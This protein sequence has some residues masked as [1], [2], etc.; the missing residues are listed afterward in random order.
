MESILFNLYTQGP[1]WFLEHSWCLINI[2]QMNACQLYRNAIIDFLCF[3]MNQ[4]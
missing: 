3:S 4:L 1:T 2:C